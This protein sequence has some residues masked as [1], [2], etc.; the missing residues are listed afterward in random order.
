MD[1]RS[2][3]SRGYGRGAIIEQMQKLAA[4]RMLDL[5]SSNGSSECSPGTVRGSGRGQLLERQS[6]SVAKVIDF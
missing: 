1:G 3:P 2:G 4:S 5:N 6:S